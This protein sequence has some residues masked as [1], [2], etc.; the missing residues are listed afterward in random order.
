M[1]CR[2][3]TIL[4]QHLSSAP[5]NGLKCVSNSVS[6]ETIITLC[7]TFS[8]LNTTGPLTCTVGHHDVCGSV[9]KYQPR[10]SL[11]TSQTQVAHTHTHTRPRKNISNCYTNYVIVKFY[12]STCREQV[13]PFYQIHQLY[14]KSSV[15]CYLRNHTTA[16]HQQSRDLTLKHGSLLKLQLTEAIRVLSPNCDFP[17]AICVPYAFWTHHLSGLSP[18]NSSVSSTRT[19]SF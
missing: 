9:C 5:N 15:L 18:I 12:L 8:P 14:R 4:A 16:T 7:V 17:S 1:L 10:S 2:E 3:Q 13:E 11:S 19:T 6:T